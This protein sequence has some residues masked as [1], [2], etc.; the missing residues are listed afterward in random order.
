ME[1]KLL[2]KLDRTTLSAEASILHVFLIHFQ[3]IHCYFTIFQLF[4]MDQSQGNLVVYSRIWSLFGSCGMILNRGMTKSYA[5]FCKTVVGI[6]E[7][8]EAARGLIQGAWREE[9]AAQAREVA[10]KMEKHRWI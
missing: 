9:A 7:G 6:A 3:E 5:Q 4:S 10:E 8:Q 2:V 1:G